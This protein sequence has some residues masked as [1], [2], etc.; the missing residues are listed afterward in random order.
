M[1]KTHVTLKD[2]YHTHVT[3]RNHEWHS[4]VPEDEDGENLAP[5]PEE[6]LMGALGSCMAM[7]GKMYAK[8]KGWQIDNIEINLDFERFRGSDYAAYDGDASFVHEIRESIVIE[9]PLDD[10]Q[11]AR[12][13][14]IM[15]KCP[16]RRVL[17]NPTFFVD[18]QPQ[19]TD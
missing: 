15:G 2:G 14:E 16:V 8:R 5:T 9:G 19:E 6:L 18:M 13:I 4:D 1:P 12:I 7:T 11:K 3:A 10:D 17:A